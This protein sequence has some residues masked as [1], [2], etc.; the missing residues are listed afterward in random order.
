[1]ILGKETLKDSELVCKQELRT[2]T[3]SSCILHA[4]RASCCAQAIC[5]VLRKSSHAL[6]K[7]LS[8]LVLREI[9]CVKVGGRPW[10]YAVQHRFG[11]AHVGHQ[12]LADRLRGRIECFRKFQFLHTCVSV[13]PQLL[14]DRAGRTMPELI[15]PAP[16]VHDRKATT[17]RTVR[18]LTCLCLSVA[19][20]PR[21]HS[22]PPSSY[23][24]TPPLMQLRQMHN[25]KLE[26][27]LF[28]QTSKV[29]DAK[30]ASHH[31]DI[32]L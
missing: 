1:M 27:C 5:T 4:C 14:A 22:P 32:D 13:G 7:L 6:Q 10:L 21:T 9:L 26:S 12:T 25:C 30:T 18:M 17:N 23:C 2:K 11:T 15:N 31:G 16:V 28:L 24:E 3:C 29:L 19:M 20:W 8:I